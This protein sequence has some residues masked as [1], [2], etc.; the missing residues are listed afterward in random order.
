[1]PSDI[2]IIIP[3]LNESQGIARAVERAWAT[4]PAEVL[5]VDGGSRD[6]TSEIAA[7]AGASVLHSQRGRAHQQNLGAEKAVG[8]IFLFLHADN[9]LAAEGLDQVT[10]ALRDPAVQCGAFW[11]RIEA[12][13]AIYRA[14][15]H[16]NAF[17]ARQLGLPYGD[18]GIFVRRSAF[19]AVGGFPDVELMEDLLL[20]RRLRKLAKPV[21]LPGP[22]SVS[23]RRWQKRG[24]LRQTLLN[25]SLFA[26]ERLGMSPDSLARYYSS[27]ENGRAEVLTKDR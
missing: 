7:A 1:M 21:L 23:A 3:A 20:M 9:W 8:E 22:I 17:R 14:I 10:R 25:W 26:A 2:S 4:G 6:Q 18:Q 16:G 15:E 5:V 19:E 13:A 11:Q 27:H 24:V 12:P